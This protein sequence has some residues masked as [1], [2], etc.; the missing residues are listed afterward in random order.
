MSLLGSRRRP[1]VFAVEDLHLSDQT[2]EACFAMLVEGLAGAPI[3]FL[4]TYRPGYR[5]P[6]LGKSYATQIALR[7]LPPQESVAVVYSILPPEKRT[8]EL[9]QA[10]LIKAEGNPF[11]LEEL[12][13]VVAEHEDVQ[14]IVTVPAT[15][16]G[17]IMARIDQLMMP[18]SGCRQPLSW[19]QHTATPAARNLGR[20]HDP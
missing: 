16:E 12:A 6:W 2:S 1:I 3:L 17:V 9:V 11:F 13:R 14:T 4:S 19:S 10:I 8:E 5:P 20:A 7:H 15:V 18:P